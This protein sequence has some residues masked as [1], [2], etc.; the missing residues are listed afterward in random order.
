[1]SVHYGEKLVI[2]CMAPKNLKNLTLTWTFI[3]QNKQTDILTYFSQTKRIKN[4][5]DD[6]AELDLNKA[7]MGDGSLYLNNLGSKHSGTYTCTFTGSQVKHIVQTLV[8]TSASTAVS[9]TGE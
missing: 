9:Q 4:H 3:S 7:L 1:M 5:W 2:P 8:N 6:R